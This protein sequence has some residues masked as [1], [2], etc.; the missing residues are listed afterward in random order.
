MD[1]RP[2]YDEQLEDKDPRRTTP[3][4][5]TPTGVKGKDPVGH[6]FRTVWPLGWHGWAC[7]SLWGK[8]QSVHHHNLQ[9]M[10][11]PHAM[12]QTEE[13][14]HRQGTVNPFLPL[15]SEAQFHVPSR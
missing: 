8:G 10:D 14:T 4:G 6:R 12:L 11:F 9:S 13:R 2:P 15:V 1:R 5:F 7:S 3:L